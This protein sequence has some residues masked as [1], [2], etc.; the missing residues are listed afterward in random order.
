MP[1]TIAQEPLRDEPCAGK[2]V[3]RTRRDSRNGE[4]LETKL[5]RE[6]QDIARPVYDA[7]TLPVRR[8]AKAWPIDAND[9]SADLLAGS[10]V[11]PSFKAAARHT[12]E[13]EH[14]LAAWIAVLG[15]PERAAVVED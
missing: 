6:L 4:A 13:F 1:L 11:V 9:T 8:K 14:R 2:R 12:M 10:I 3:G 7:V 5:V 15:K